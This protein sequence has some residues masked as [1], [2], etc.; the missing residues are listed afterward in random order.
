MFGF[1]DDRM[2]KQFQ[3]VMMNM[4]YCEYNFT[5]EQWM[6]H[7]DRALLEL[8]KDPE[9]K[10]DPEKLREHYRQEWRTFVALRGNSRN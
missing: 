6:T 10:S 9:F 4:L 5:E 3:L 7:V 8:R 1:G 2:H